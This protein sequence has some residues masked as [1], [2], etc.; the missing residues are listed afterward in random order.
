MV[1]NCFVVFLHENIS[2]VDFLCRII[3]GGSKY[4]KKCRK[5]IWI[6]FDFK[7][8]LK[9]SRELAVKEFIN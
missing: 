3:G 2:V 9:I 5:I 4:L 1:L 6:P 8:I 7:E